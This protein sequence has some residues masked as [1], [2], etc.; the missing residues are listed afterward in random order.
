MA[1]KLREEEIVSVAYEMAEKMYNI[2]RQEFVSLRVDKDDYLQDA[3]MYI[4]NLYKSKYMKLSNNIKPH[5]MIFRMLG[6]FTKNVFQKNARDVSR[7]QLTLDRPMGDDSNTTIA[8]QLPS[9]FKSNPEELMLDEKDFEMGKKIVNEIIETLDVVPYKTTKHTYTGEH[10]I[11]GK[12]LKLSEYNI[13]RLLM[14][15]VDEYGILHVYNSYAKNI[16]A[17]SRA[18]FVHRKTKNAIRKIANIINN[19]LPEEES[20]I[21]K[22]YIFKIM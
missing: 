22:A 15:G 1:S 7:Y 19:E 12:N 13:G 16:G 10:P 8:D 21:A 14:L 9:N 17:D 6:R 11:L 3:V 2:R 5:G 20:K 18:T 4:L